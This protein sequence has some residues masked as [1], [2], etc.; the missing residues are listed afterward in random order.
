MCFG[1]LPGA[2]E[3]KQSDPHRLHDLHLGTGSLCPSA[4]KISKRHSLSKV[5]KSRPKPLHSDL[6]FELCNELI[7]W[8][9]QDCVSPHYKQQYLDLGFYGLRNTTA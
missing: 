9:E 1:D 5:T 7:F 3:A 4:G 2:L 8:R 6:L